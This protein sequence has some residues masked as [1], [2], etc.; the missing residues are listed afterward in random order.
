MARQSSG[1]GRSE[2][3]RAEVVE[4]VA[5]IPNLAAEKI[6]GVTYRHTKQEIGERLAEALSQAALK[7]VH[8]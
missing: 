3:S 8:E 1:E 4:F 7:I 5:G 6:A 2:L